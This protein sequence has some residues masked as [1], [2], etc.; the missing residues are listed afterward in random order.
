MLL[1]SG[2]HMRRERALLGESVNQQWNHECN[3]VP[4][5]KHLPAYIDKQAHLHCRN[6]AGSRSGT[7]QDPHLSVHPLPD[8][9]KTKALPL[10]AAQEDGPDV[11]E[12]V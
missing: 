11:G 5:L 6:P 9:G 4:G 8:T 1:A 3:H 7:L 2:V 12:Q 10:R